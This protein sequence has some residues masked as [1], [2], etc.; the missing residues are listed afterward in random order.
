MDRASVMGIIFGIA[1]IVG[2]NLFEGGRLDSIMQLTAAVIV[3]G[4]TFGAVLLSFPLRDILKAISSLR[5]IFMDGKTNPETSINSIIRYSNIVRRKGLIALEPEI[6]KIKDYFLRKA[7]KLAVDGMGP[8]ILKEAMEQENLTY[9]EERR[10]IAR[11]FETAGGFAP[12]IGII[13][14]VLGLIQVMENLSDPSRLGSGIAVA[15]VA[16]IYGVGSANLILLPISKKLLN[17]LNHE[18]SVREIVLEG[19]V[20][21][22]SGINPY[23]LEES[24]R[25]FIERDRTRISR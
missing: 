20:G 11:V 15:F 4:G 14:A 13:G 24:L 6:S 18:L 16:T 7:L 22:Q 5:D 3:F 17:K 12:T 23:Y 10:R 1:A 21:I 9:E 2:G 8:K 19:V 25:V